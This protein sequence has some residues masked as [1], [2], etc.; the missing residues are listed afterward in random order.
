MKPQL[1]LSL[2][3]GIGLIDRAFEEQ[4]FVVVR[5]PDVLWGGDIRNFHPPAG[6]FDGVIGGPPCQ[7]FSSLDQNHVWP[8]KIP[9]AISETKNHGGISND[10]HGL[11]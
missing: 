10:P 5:G 11:I 3:P 6:K 8:L 2:F 9:P 4:G 1:V 7:T